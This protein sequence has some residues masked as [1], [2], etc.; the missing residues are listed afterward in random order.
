MAGVRKRGILAWLAVAGVGGS[1]P[2]MADGPAFKEY[3]VKAAFLVHFAEFVEWPATAF[4]SADAPIAIGV[5]GGDVFKGALEKAAASF[6]VG[7]R[8]LVIRHL[9][10]SDQLRTCHVL[11]VGKEQKGPAQVLA[12]VKG[13]PVLTVG[14]TEGFAEDGGAI[15]F[16]LQG[17][18]LRFEINRGVAQG[19]GLKI[20]A[21]L[22]ALG[23]LVGGNGAKEN[24]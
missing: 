24:R 3:D 16:F 9:T 7:N 19:N 5:L 10:R 23:K 20:S 12:D 17:S 2:C 14:E 22:L 1:T 18:R 8:K 4:A 6:T 13:A 11:F 21:Q 15:N